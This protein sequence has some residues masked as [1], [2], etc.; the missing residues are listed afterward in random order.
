MYHQYYLDALEVVLAWDLPDEAIA[1][2]INHQ[3]KLNTGFD[4]EDIW[5]RYPSNTLT[6]NH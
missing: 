4:D 1:N 3:V 5:E 6:F 2:A